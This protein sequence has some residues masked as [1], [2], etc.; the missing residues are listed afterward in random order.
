MT[1]S[2]SGRGSLCGL[3]TVSWKTPQSI[4]QQDSPHYDRSPTIAH[5]FVP[6]HVPQKSRKWGWDYSRDPGLP[7]RSATQKEQGCSSSLGSSHLVWA[8]SSTGDVYVKTETSQGP[9]TDISPERREVTFE[10]IWKGAK[11]T[12]RLFA[13]WSPTHSSP[14]PQSQSLHPQKCSPQEAGPQTDK[15]LCSISKLFLNTLLLKMLD[16]V[17]VVIVI[18]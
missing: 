14:V 13:N 12:S 2:T 18:I 5:T 6:Q 17:I 3:H 7:D 8:G 4:H 15:C 16:Y 1:W 11:V 10:W 9:L